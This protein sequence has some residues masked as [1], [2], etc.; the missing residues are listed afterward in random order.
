[1]KAKRE[2]KY[3]VRYISNFANMYDL[4]WADSENLIAMLK[5]KDYEQI[6]R[7]EAVRLCREE[8]QRR[9]YDPSFSGYA[10]TVVI[11]ADMTED[12]IYKLSMYP[13][14]MTFVDV[15]KCI[16]DRI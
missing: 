4:R 13:E 1:M 3:F 11:P 10:D 7:E 8:K 5:S 14:K 12:T 16:L 15:G 6:T 9:K 2:R